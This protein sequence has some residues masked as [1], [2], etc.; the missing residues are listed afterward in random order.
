MPLPLDNEFPV[1]VPSLEENKPAPRIYG[2]SMANSVQREGGLNL[3][4][5]KI[6][7]DESRWA[8]GGYQTGWERVE[9]PSAREP[10]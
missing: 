10:D 5:I 9:E 4:D 7:A 1:V 8:W 6:E 3:G 2:W